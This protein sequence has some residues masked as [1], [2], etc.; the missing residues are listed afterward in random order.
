MSRGQIGLGRAM[1]WNLFLAVLPLLF[2]LAFIKC[3]QRENRFLTGFYFVLWLLFLPNAPYLLTDLIHIFDALGAYDSNQVKPAKL[4]SLLAMLLS[5]AGT[6][7]LLGYF[8][9]F[10]VQQ[11]IEVKRGARMGWIVAVSSLMLCGFGIYLGRFLRWNSWDV[12]VHPLRFARLML[13][14]T[15]HFDGQPQPLVVT[16]VFGIGL[17]LGYVALRVFAAGL[18]EK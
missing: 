15:T 13:G 8:S 11:I 5:C 17:I 9:L 14:K 4:W 7:T 18:Q 1:I 3:M 2:G 12:F 16:F 6:G 10:D